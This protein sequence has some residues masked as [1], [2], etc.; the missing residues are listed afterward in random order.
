M[1][2]QFGKY[3]VEHGHGIFGRRRQ[4]LVSLASRRKLLSQANARFPTVS[5]TDK[6][7]LDLVSVMHVGRMNLHMA[8]MAHPLRHDSCSGTL[9]ALVVQFSR[10]LPSIC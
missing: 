5:V 8:Q 2:S 1:P 4:H 6:A 9:D 3:H 10:Q 7:I